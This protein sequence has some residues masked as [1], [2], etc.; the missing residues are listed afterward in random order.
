[1]ASIF[2][3]P[4]HPVFGCHFQ[5]KNTCPVILQL[6]AVALL[7]CTRCGF[8]GLGETRTKNMDQFVINI[9]FVIL[10]AIS[11]QY[12]SPVFNTFFSVD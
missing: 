9:G 1:M 7:S 4:I 6:S 3:R 10:P 11:T 12:F 2:H 5:L 8:T